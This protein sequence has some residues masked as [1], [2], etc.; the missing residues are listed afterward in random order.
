MQAP[1][2][3]TLAILAGLVTAFFLVAGIEFIGHRIYPPPAD[4]DISNVERFAAYEQFAA[5]GKELPVGAL[6][7]VIAAWLTATFS[8]RL[9][10]W[11]IAGSR[12]MLVAGSTATVEKSLGSN[13]RRGAAEFKR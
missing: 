11:V 6:L 1:Y 5:Y 7:I 8:G 2:R 4:V 12:P 10:A 9:I 3:F 13:P